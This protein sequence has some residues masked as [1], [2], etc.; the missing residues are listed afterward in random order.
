[1]FNLQ[2]FAE[3]VQG[4]QIVYLYRILEEA[5]TSAAV[6]LAFVTEDSLTMSK[7][8]ETTITKDGA[9]RTPGAAEVEKTATTLLAKGDTM[10]DKLKKAMLEDKIVEIW[11]ANLA[12][13]VEGGE[14]KFKGTYY[15]GYLTEFEK[16]ASSEEAVEISTTFGINGAGVDGEVTVTTEQQEV[17]AYI[18]KDT[19]ATGA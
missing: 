11:E 15:Q 14:N 12:E 16:T 18:F 5:A 10:Y 3:A 9:I 4:T 2:L 8:S 13:P 7:D 17:A 19:Q 6:A 1:M